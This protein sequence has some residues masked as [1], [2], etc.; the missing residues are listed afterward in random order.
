M[1]KETKIREI[2]EKIACE[3]YAKEVTEDMCTLFDRIQEL[4]T[5]LVHA[6]VDLYLTSEDLNNE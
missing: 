2:V 6:E 4:E 1:T 3:H 5:Q